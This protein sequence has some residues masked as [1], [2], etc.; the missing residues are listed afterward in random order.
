MSAPAQ[1]LREVEHVS[2]VVAVEDDRA[3]RLPLSGVAGGRGQIAVVVPL[4]GDSCCPARLVVPIG[5]KARW[6]FSRPWP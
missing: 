4:T 3:E 2:A 5:W 1:R 6:M